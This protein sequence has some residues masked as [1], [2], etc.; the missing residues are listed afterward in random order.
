MLA[1]TQLA[2]SS[3]PPNNL[4]RKEATYKQTNYIFIKELLFSGGPD[5]QSITCPTL[6][7]KV[8]LKQT[9]QHWD[10]FR[11]PVFSTMDALLEPDLHHIHRSRQ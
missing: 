10:A 9:Q 2:W 8:I 5:I 6:E 3:N 7:S 1:N 4:L 11:R